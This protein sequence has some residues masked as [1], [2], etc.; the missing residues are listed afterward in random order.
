K[1]LMRIRVVNENGGKASISQYVIR[2]LIRTSDLTVLLIIFY[3]PFALASGIQGFIAI[4]GAGAL[5]LTDII[6]VASS[7]KA[8][9]LGDLLAG[10]IL[11]RTNPKGSIDETVFLEIADNYIPSFPQIMQLSDKDINSIKSILDTSRKKGDFQLAAMASEKI[12]SHLKIDSSLS[13]Y[14][15][16]EILMKDYNYLSVK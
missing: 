2:W 10:T 1:K 6:L 4:G 13:P 3:L 11:I 12:K 14:D 8:Q 16:L 7:K 5:L 15:F 9:R